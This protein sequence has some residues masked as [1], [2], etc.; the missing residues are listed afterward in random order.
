MLGWHWCAQNIRGFDLR[1]EQN[2]DWRI[3][4]QLPLNDTRQRQ[5]LC[6]CPVREL[7]LTVALSPPV[8]LRIT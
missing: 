5:L 8:F 6:C 4:I 2:Y 1:D 3:S 7:R